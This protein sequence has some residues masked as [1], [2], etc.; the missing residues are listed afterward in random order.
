MYLIEQYGHDVDVALVCRSLGVVGFLS[1]MA[2][3]AAL[4]LRMIDG[5]GLTYSI[6]KVL[7]ATLVLISLTTDF[8]LSAALIQVSFLVIGLVGIVIRLRGR[9]HPRRLDR[10]AD[11]DQGITPL[12]PQ[13][14]V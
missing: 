8:N 3:Y 5:D 1:Y 6:S 10:V 9:R 11:R 13:K 4:Q 14:L 7:G 2:G 12:M